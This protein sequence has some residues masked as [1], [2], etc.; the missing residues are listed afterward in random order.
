M[1][2]HS[3]LGVMQ[4]VDSLDLGGTETVAVNLANRLPRQRFRNYVCST[5]AGL[6]GGLLTSILQPDVQ[7]L[8]LNRKWKLDIPAMLRFR[9]FIRHENIDLLHVHG[10]SLF[11]GRMASMFGL[12]AGV[13]MIWHDHYGRCELN[14]RPAGL[15]RLAVSGAR[16]V[17]AVNQHLVNW[18]CRELKM[19]PDRVWYVPNFVVP[20]KIG[21]DMLAQLPG[22]S[23]KRIVC[24]ANLRPQ[25]DHLTLIRAMTGV[26][27]NDP[28]AHLLI[29]GAPL[30]VAYTASLH[31]ETAR[32]ALE[33][34]ITFVGQ[35]DDVP[36]ILRACDVGVLSSA[37]E[38]LPL[39]LLEYGWAGL[40]SVATSVGQCAEVLDHGRVGM[41]VNPGVPEQLAAAIQALLQSPSKR[42]QTGGAFQ[43]FV[44]KTFD[45]A[46]IVNQVCDIYDLALS[47][48]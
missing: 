7:H 24:V 20:S 39:S 35:I 10:S 30:D 16:G 29:V 47:T 46:A 37:S 43:A 23:G 14:D 41:L 34:N 42:S 21:A 18:A 4:V 11:F 33:K 19:S 31:Q 12:S 28:E 45:P 26:C 2:K 48:N 3:T 40:A 15:Y 8:A 38:G 1:S 22:S 36:S 32:L 5:R 13:R 27:Q 25:K 44:R 17:I 9:K 6:D